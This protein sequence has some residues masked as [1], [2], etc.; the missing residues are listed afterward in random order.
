MKNILAT[1]DFSAIA[2]NAVDYAMNLAKET[3]ADVTLFNCYHIPV[4]TGDGPVITVPFEELEAA[5]TDMLNTRK[6]NLENKFPGVKINVVSKAGFATDEIADY[7]KSNPID[8]IIMG[9]S[10]SGNFDRLL[11]ST[12]TAVSKQSKVP[13]LIVPGKAVFKKPANIVV[14]FDFKEVE[15]TSSVNLVVELAKQFG[16]RITALNVSQH[17]EVSLEQSLA[18]RQANDL[19]SDVHHRMVNYNDTDAITGIEHYLKSHDVD[20]LVMLKRKHGFFDTLLHGS[21][22][23]KMAF[24]TH[25]PLLVLHD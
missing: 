19:L 18:S 21:N 2:D 24:H 4:V 5:S 7:I 8:M 12:A 14:A 9:I 16:S 6:K 11:G 20:M 25:V 10:G 23:R 15:N 13:V 1:T 22:T 3:R 17:H